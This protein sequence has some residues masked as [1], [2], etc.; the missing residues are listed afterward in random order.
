MRFATHPPDSPEVVR[1]VTP[2][3][4]F[5]CPDLTTL[6]AHIAELREHLGPRSGLTDR[7]KRATRAD[8]DRLLERR[9]WL[10]MCP[11]A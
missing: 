5:D 2:G 10:Q 9:M 3:Y 11:A 7:R 4:F 1:S 6:D 8:I